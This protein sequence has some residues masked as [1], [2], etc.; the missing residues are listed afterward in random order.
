MPRMMRRRK[1][2]DD[3][4]PGMPPLPRSKQRVI[5]RR[6]RPGKA[7]EHLRHPSIFVRRREED[8]DGADWE[9]VYLYLRREREYSP[10]RRRFILRRNRARQN[11]NAN[12]KTS[13][14]DIMLTCTTVLAVAVLAICFLATTMLLS[15]SKAV[16][17]LLR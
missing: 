7:K 11:A 8:D 1:T 16:T 6:L 9:R 14:K 15:Q 5:S 3:T 10:R 2:L 17:D 13:W 12:G 4:R